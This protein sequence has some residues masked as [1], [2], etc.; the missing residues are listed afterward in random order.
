VIVA[1][2][3]CA[4]SVVAQS[5]RK[6]GAPET[7][8]ATANVATAGGAG[9]TNVQLVVQRYTPDA[10]R[11]AVENALKG[12]GYPAFVAALRKAS[13]VGQVEFGG[14]TFAIRY[15]RQTETPKGRTIVLVT[16]KPVFFVGGAAPDAKSRAGYE[17]AVIRLEMHEAGMGTGVMAAAA[18]VKPDPEGGVL[19]DDYAEKPITLQMVR[20]KI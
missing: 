17:V 14:Q 15:A 3:L 4:A 11:G 16:D 9:T 13:E 19:L 2:A 5:S 20:R 1:A 7:F 10:E 12:G 18:R 8:T 6:P